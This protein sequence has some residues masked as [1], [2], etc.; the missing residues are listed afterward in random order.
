MRMK[1]DQISV[2]QKKKKAD[3]LVALLTVCLLLFTLGMAGRQVYAEDHTVLITMDDTVRLQLPVSDG[4]VLLPECPP[5]IAA[6]HKQEAGDGDTF[7]G[8]QEKGADDSVAAQKAGAAFPVGEKTTVA[9]KSVWRSADRD[10]TKEPIEPKKAAAA[11]KSSVKSSPAAA[12]VSQ[13]TVYVNQSTGVDTN[14]G[15]KDQPVNTLDAAAG[16]LT[17]AA[18]GGT[19]ENNKILIQG[20]YSLGTGREITLFARDKSVP[21]TIEGDPEKDAELSQKWTTDQT[22]SFVNLDDDLCLQKMKAT[23]IEHIYGQGHNITIGEGVNNYGNIEGINGAR[24]FYLYGAGNNEI[25]NKKVGEIVVRSGKT[26]R[27]AGYVRSNPSLDAQNLPAKITISGTAEV[28]TIITGN[29]SGQVINAE[30]E[31]TVAGGKVGTLV[32]GN[33][34]FN[35]APSDFWGNTAIRISGGTV[36][37]VLGAGTGRN[38]SIPTYTGHLSIEVYGGNAKNIYGGGSAAFVTKDGKVDIKI[39]GGTVGDVF[40]AGQGGDGAIVAPDS[41][42][43]FTESQDLFGSMLGTATITIADNAVVTGNIYASG[44]GFEPAS[45]KKYDTTKNA[46]LGGKADI[47]IEGGTVKG[48][49]Y[50]GG[51]GIN[52][53]GY[54]QCARVDTGAEAKVTLSGGTVEGS[55]Y[56]GGEIAKV[57]SKTQVVISKGRVKGNVYG[58]GKTA[59]VTGS[60]EVTLSG[61]NNNT[62]IEGNVYGGGEKGAVKGGTTVNIKQA[63]IQGSVYGG[64]LGE[65]NKVLVEGRSTVNMT[66]GWVQKNLYGGSELS[67]DGADVSAGTA[68]PD[69]VFVNLVGGTVD[70]NVFGGGYKGTVNGSTHLHIGEG[71]LGEC[72][73]YQEHPEDKPDLKPSALSVSGSVYAGGDYGGGAAGYDDITV[74]GTSH[75]YIDGTNYDTGQNNNA[76]QMTIAGGVFGSGASCDAGSTRLV[77]LKN[78]GVRTENEKKAASG[79]T[80]SLK[81]IQRADRV[82]LLNSHVQ[83]T[84]Q[85][86]AANKDQTALYSLNRVGDHGE[87]KVT[88]ALGTGLV[89]QSGSTLV[90]ESPVIELAKFQSLDGSA[91]DVKEEGIT[92][93][94]NTL[95]LNT[96]T[97]FRVAYSDSNYGPV[98]GYAYLAAGEKADAY[99]YARQNPNT[100]DSDGGFIDLEGKTISFTN[101]DTTYR[102]W[103]VRNGTQVQAVRE[104]VLT[105]RTLQSGDS[106]YG[107]DGFSVAAGEIDLPPAAK[108]S[109]YKIQSITAPSGVTFTEAAKNETSAWTTSDQNN[110]AS[111]PIDTEKEQKKIKDDPLSSFG[112]YMKSGSGFGT[113]AA[114]KVVSQRSMNAADPN[115]IINTSMGSIEETLVEPQIQFYLTY[116][117][118]GITSSKE[119]GTVEVVLNRYDSKNVLQETTTMKVKIVTRATALTSQ[120][121]DLY[122]TQGG[123]YTGKLLIP[124]GSDHTFSL[125]KVTK[126]SSSLVP[127]N[128]TITDHSFAIQMEPEQDQAWKSIKNKTLDLGAFS[129]A[130]VI[131]E[132]DGRYEAPVLFTLKNVKDFHGKDTADEIVLTLSDSSVNPAETFDVTLRVNWKESAVS[133][134]D[135]QSGRQYNGLT[136]SDSVSINAKSAITAQFTLRQQ[137]AVASLWLELQDN[138]GTRV[139]LPEGTRI[140]LIQPANFYTYEV[141]GAETDSKIQL[142]DYTLMWSDTTQTLTGNLST[143]PFAMI[144]DFESAKESIKTGDHSLRLRTE[145]GADSIGASFTINPGS[146]AISLSGGNGLSRGEHT[147]SLRF[148][149][150]SDT[151]LSGDAVAVLSPA[152]GK[153]FPKGTLFK[154][155]GKTYYPNQGKV[156]LPLSDDA[157]EV[158]MDTTASAGLAAGDQVINAELFSTGHSTGKTA[159]PLVKTSITYTV[160]ANPVYGIKVAADDEKRIAASGTK[161]SFKADYSVENQKSGGGLKIEV[162]VQQKEEKNYVPL[163]SPWTVTGNEAITTGFGSQQLSVQIPEDQAPG[164]YRL[165]FTLG[166]QKVPYNVIVSD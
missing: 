82:L 27:I 128:G 57:G 123:S 89:L 52:K 1:I 127:V 45:D 114:G 121:V 137:T 100:G 138:S 154:Y 24:Y 145:D 144:V 102:Y 93:C 109:S 61:E 105:A 22:E 146:A 143:T 103:Q 124:S 10:E 142:K 20:K 53:T 152:A 63:T 13:K 33:Q 106:G 80:R 34:G 166:D 47:S 35:A 94:S 31:I 99:A 74:K 67:N 36:N 50:G 116:D 70:H 78:Y 158:I 17:K 14:D 125:T 161:L 55:I 54:E 118:E 135:V 66:G 9:L 48:S 120:T 136:P 81:A 41:G 2:M 8:W 42:K 5:E 75:V 163:A 51:R 7:A 151:R 30:A 21:V 60:A 6:L 112:L 37:N 65:T 91:Q 113:A 32:G 4:A 98:K 43:S 111:T 59:D 132:T 130:T 97:I 86:D 85:S 62:V 73:Y 117:N 129:T 119:I 95:L 122:A 83:L 46:Y 23:G 164:T 3:I 108:D 77:T 115:N 134:I 131:G 148:S 150:G 139:S 165:L 40:A 79:A 141:T 84:G 159:A 101:V 72:K 90:L 140:T 110:N 11:A 29:A 76:H 107:T 28:D 12:A 156:Y 44:S 26:T 155:S 87:D 96:G 88:D 49:I 58:G 64:A 69:L 92:S 157:Q 25:L 56:G 38:Q 147:F 15:T 133:K 68:L 18:D 39:S 153:S 71:A 162:A 16:K 126:G 104:T 160:E 149:A 19:V